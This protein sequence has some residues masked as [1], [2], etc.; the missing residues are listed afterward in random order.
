MFHYLLAFAGIGPTEFI[1]FGLIA[2]LLFGT[3]L[4]KVARSFGQSIS[5]FKKGLKEVKNDV[6][7]EL[8]NDAAE[9]CPEEQTKNGEKTESDF[10][11]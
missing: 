10:Q 7:S 8:E 9:K 6:S 3:R 5:E 11:N 1:V 4:P 2:L